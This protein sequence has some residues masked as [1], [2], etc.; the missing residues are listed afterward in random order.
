MAEKGKKLFRT[1]NNNYGCNACLESDRFNRNIT[2]DSLF[3]RFL[4]NSKCDHCYIYKWY[5]ELEEYRKSY[6]DDE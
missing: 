2:T 3:Y 6:Q 1:Y 5:Q 4:N